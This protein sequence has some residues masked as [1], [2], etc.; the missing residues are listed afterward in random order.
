MSIQEYKEYRRE[1]HQV[2]FYVDLHIERFYSDLPDDE[3]SK[4]RN[5]FIKAC[6]DTINLEY[7][8]QESNRRKK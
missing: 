7:N 6:L 1:C 5:Y 3:K 8:I 2:P 4:I